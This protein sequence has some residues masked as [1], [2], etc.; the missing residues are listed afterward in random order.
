MSR[1]NDSNKQQAENKHRP[2]GG[3]LCGEAG[4]G[5]SGN[6]AGTLY[7]IRDYFLMRRLALA[8]CIVS[9][10]D[11]YQVRI[12]G[13]N[14]AISTSMIAETITPANTVPSVIMP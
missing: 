5:A 6:F 12:A 1:A 2:H 4:F 13:P 9:R 7:A 10:A 14:I 11:R 3:I 8:A